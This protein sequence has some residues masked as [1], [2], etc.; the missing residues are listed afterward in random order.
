MLRELTN[1]KELDFILE[2]ENKVIVIDFYA[3]YCNP[4]KMIE[5]IFKKYSLNEELNKYFIFIKIDVDEA[6]DIADKYNISSMPTFIA[7]YKKEK[8]REF[9]GANSKKL[10]NLFIEA[11]NKIK[12]NN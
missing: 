1:L 8:L 11:L 10:E 9:V 12:S 6:E 5:P 4:C 2:N 3:S 7:F